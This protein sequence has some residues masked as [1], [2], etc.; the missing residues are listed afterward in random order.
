MAKYFGNPD[1]A[2]YH[3]SIQND[4]SGTGGKFVA[5]NESSKN[6]HDVAWRYGCS[7]VGNS[8]DLVDPF[9]HGEQYLLVAAMSIT[10]YLATCVVPGSLNS[11]TFFDFIVDDM[12]CT[13][14]Y[15][16]LPDL[17]IQ[18]WS[19]KLLQMNPYPDNHSVIIMDNCQIHHTDTLQDVL[20]DSGN[21]N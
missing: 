17:L 5:V 11:F 15:A 19:P 2:T 10:G 9:I 18:P 7:P 4:F 14:Q 13:I 12:V 6:E 8:A 20:N 16:S 3:H 1:G 21:W